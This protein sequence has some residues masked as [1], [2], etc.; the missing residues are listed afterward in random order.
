VEEE[1]ERG[2][3]RERKRRRKGREAP[4]RHKASLWP[5]SY[6]ITKIALS[7]P[8]PDFLEANDFNKWC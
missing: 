7:A 3:E 6:R 5:S 1:R 4:L 2:R 8:A